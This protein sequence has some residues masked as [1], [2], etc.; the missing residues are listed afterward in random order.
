MDTIEEVNNEYEI[1]LEKHEQLEKE[2]SKMKSQLQDMEIQISIINAKNNKLSNSKQLLNTQ[3]E[4]KVQHNLKLEESVR[5]K[6]YL[7][8]KINLANQERKEKENDLEERLN[9]MNQIIIQQDL[10][11]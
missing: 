5:I 3:L 7:T 2:N 1:K 6:D 4:K 9:Q 10:E 8:Q 11:K